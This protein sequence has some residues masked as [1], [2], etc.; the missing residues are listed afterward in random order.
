MKSFARMSGALVSLFVLLAFSFAQDPNLKAATYAAQQ[1]L[2]TVDAGHYGESWDRAASVFQQKVSQEQ[3]G[4]TM[5]SFRAPLGKLVS[6]Q[7]KNASYATD[8]PNA[9]AGKYYVIQFRTTF[10]D[11]PTVN[12]TVTTMQEPNGQWRVSAYEFQPADE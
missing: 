7:L 10:A 8:V 3:W 11:Y 2:T 6:R 4:E 5:I 9:P 1:W 12:E